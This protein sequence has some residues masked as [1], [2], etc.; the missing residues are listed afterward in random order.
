MSQETQKLEKGT[1]IK[2]LNLMIKAEDDKFY[3]FSF[4]HG[5]DSE[6]FEIPQFFFESIMMYTNYLLKKEIIG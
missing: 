1:L 5:L 2:N 6:W 3:C 4:E